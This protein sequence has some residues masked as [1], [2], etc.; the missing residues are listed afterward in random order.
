M[1]KIALL[2]SLVLYC[3]LGQAQDLF[4]KV[5]VT[6][7]TKDIQMTPAF[8]NLLKT[9]QTSIFEF[10][11]NRKWTEDIIQPNERIEVNLLINIV[12]WD[13]ANQFSATAQ[14]QLVR[15]VYGTSYNSQVLNLS[16]KDWAFTYNESEALEF[17]ETGNKSNLTSM[18]A[19][20][21]YLL[22]GMDYDTFSLEGGT[23]YFTKA[24][25]IVNNA[26]NN[27]EK[28][29]KP[30][31]DTRN[32]YWI[33]ENLLNSSLRPYRQVM[34]Q[35]HRLG[36][37]MMSQ[38]LEEGRK[39]ISECIPLL[40]RAKLE[41]PSGVI[42]SLFFSAKVDEIVNIY[43]KADENT[44]TMVVAKFSEMDPANGT[45]YQKILTN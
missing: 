27:A 15:P 22:I 42:F 20:Y 16:D 30:Y 6:S 7:A 18:L 10:M 12:A 45:K 4:C 8:Q 35:Y 36:M 38:K 19:Y 17:V 2:I 39:V 28:G 13:Q 44:K 37:D 41:R 14:V 5:Q 29:W 1:K 3:S 23:P 40:Q 21:A 43:S 25:A 24:Q 33:V 32:R 34:Y 31:E 11:N 9:L 26:Q